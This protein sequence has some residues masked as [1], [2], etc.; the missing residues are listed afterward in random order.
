M[1][2]S[3]FVLPYADVGAGIRPSSGAKLFFYASGTS[4]FKSTFTDGTGSTPHANPVIANANGVFPSIFLEGVFNI[5]LKDTND[6]QIWTEDPYTTSLFTSP[7]FSTVAAMVA[8]TPTAL[9]G[10]AVVF[11]VGMFVSVVDYATGNDSGVMFGS[12]VAGGTGTADGGSYIDLANG[13]Q[14]EQ[15][16]QANFVSIKQFGASSASSAAFNTV[17]IQSAI[18]AISAGGAVFIPLGTYLISSQLTVRDKNRIY[19]TGYGSIIKLDNSSNDNII[20]V[21]TESGGTILENFSLDGNKANNTLGSCIS[22]TSANDMY[23]RHVKMLNPVTNGITLQTGSHD[24]AVIDCDI[25]GAG[26]HGVSISSSDRMIVSTNRIQ[27][28]VQAGV[29]CSDSDFST[30]TGNT[31]VSTL[32]ATDNGY[33]GI[34][35]PNGSFY[36]TATGNTITGHSRGIFILSDSRFITVNSNMIRSC[37]LQGILIDGASGSGLTDS[38]TVTSNTILNAGVFGTSGAG[39][40]IRIT[41]SD[42][43]QCGNNNIRD[44]GTATTEWGIRETGSNYNNFTGCLIRGTLSGQISMSG[45]S[46]KA[47]SITSAVSHDIA[48]AATLPLPD[49]STWFNV[50]GTTTITAINGNRFDRIVTLRFSGALTVTDGASLYLA[51]DF[52]TSN[53]STLTLMSDESQWWEVSR[54]VN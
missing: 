2:L 12:I 40:G 19:G 16:F 4:T 35:F 38:N 10:V 48:S 24:S 20:N 54:S 43:N 8:A 14:W 22:C 42:N 52:V 25:I 27:D 46:S 31:I 17:A 5:A 15:N 49:E 45:S 26:Q 29:N 41:D 7:V 32:A 50:T 36:C 23:V 44:T 47:D 39:D 30:I 11:T 9:D 51:G 28:V 53:S 13:M 1:A 3:R 33:G 37:G 18:N 34:R 6:V 21:N